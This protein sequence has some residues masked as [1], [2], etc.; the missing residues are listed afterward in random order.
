M[1]TPSQTPSLFLLSEQVTPNS[2][3]SKAVHM[4]LGFVLSLT[5]WLAFLDAAC[6]MSRLGKLHRAI[7][8]FHPLDQS[9]SSNSGGNSRNDP[10]YEWEACSCWEAGTIKGFVRRGSISQ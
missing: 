8:I 4:L 2:R 7:D 5:A 1:L 3:C 10:V 6:V 9:C